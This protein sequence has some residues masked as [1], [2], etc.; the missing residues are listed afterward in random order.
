MRDASGLPKTIA[1]GNN[2][3]SIM[4]TV[5]RDVVMILPI[6]LSRLPRPDDADTNFVVVV[7]I[8]GFTA[9]DRAE[10]ASA[11][12]INPYS[13][14]PRVRTKPAAIN[15]DAIGVDTASNPLQTARLP[16]FIW[17]ALT[18]DSARQAFSRTIYVSTRESTSWLCL[19]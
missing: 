19:S 4:A 18:V 10:I 6:A 13:S 17:P 16:G 2:I 11:I 5:A 8:A 14:V 1:I 15:S 9:V 3:K 12:T 7:A